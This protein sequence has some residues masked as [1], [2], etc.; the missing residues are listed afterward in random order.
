M[1][2]LTEHA[3]CVLPIENQVQAIKN[4]FLTNKIFFNLFFTHSQSCHKKPSQKFEKVVITTT[5]RLSEWALINDSIQEQSFTRT[6]HYN[7]YVI[8]QTGLTMVVLTRAGYLWEWSQGEFWPWHC[9]TLVL[10]FCA[11]GDKGLQIASEKLS[12]RNL[13]LYKVCMS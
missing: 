7:A 8:V 6:F 13:K 11:T 1:H 2:Q 10:A 9:I 4:A 12:L 5:G 3:D